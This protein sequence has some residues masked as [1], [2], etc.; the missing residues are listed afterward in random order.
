MTEF[1]TSIFRKYSKDCSG[2]IAVLTALL[3]VPVMIAASVAID[4]Q[5]LHSEVGNLQSALDTATL[6]AVTKG[7]LSEADRA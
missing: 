7:K 4:T 6:A 2:N 5:K 3:G 1:M